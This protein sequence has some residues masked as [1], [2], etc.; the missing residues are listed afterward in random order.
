MLKIYDLPQSRKHEFQM[1][2][3]MICNIF[4]GGGDYEECYEW[5]LRQVR[6][7]PWSVGT[8]RSLMMIGDA[9]PHEPD[10]YLNKDN[11]DWRAEASALYNEQGVGVI[12]NNYIISFLLDISH[13]ASQIKTWPC[14]VYYSGI[15][16]RI[17]PNYVIP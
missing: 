13:C 14:I 8:Q 9:I 7:L 2:H 17:R 16:I 10:Y 12:Y 11:L 5:V 6:E 4:P 3:H 1:R 15:L